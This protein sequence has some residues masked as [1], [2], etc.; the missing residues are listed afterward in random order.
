ML[1]FIDVADLVPGEVDDLQQRPVALFQVDHSARIQLVI[2]YINKHLQ[3]FS[4]SSF[5]Q[6]ARCR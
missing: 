3:R 6:L 5:G 4:S 1:G 2:G